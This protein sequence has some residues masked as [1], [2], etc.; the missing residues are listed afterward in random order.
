MQSSRLVWIYFGLIFTLCVNT[1]NP[2]FSQ[3]LTKI[4][5]VSVHY[6]LHDN[7]Q[8]NA[9]NNAQDNLQ[10]TKHHISKPASILGSD[11]EPHCSINLHC[12]ACFALNFCVEYFSFIPS[13]ISIFQEFS[14]NLKTRQIKPEIR[15]P[16]S[17]KL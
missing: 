1:I 10:K 15:P 8:D 9:Q 4:N 6:Y 13:P 16:K 5:Q 17:S 3:A 14:S 11:A 2:V 12:H 7:V